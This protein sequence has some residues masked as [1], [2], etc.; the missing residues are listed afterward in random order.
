MAGLRA[1][2]AKHGVPLLVDGPGPVFQTYITDQAAVT[3]YR[4]FAACDRPAMTRFH[5]G[6]FAAGISIVPRGLWFL[7]TE[8]TANQIDETIAAADSALAFL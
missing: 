6:L 5:A 4:T 8:H 2:A 3:D 1:A 7:S